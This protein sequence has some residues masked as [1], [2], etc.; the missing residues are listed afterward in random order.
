MLFLPF[1]DVNPA[2]LQS[3]ESIAGFKNLSSQIRVVEVLI[4]GY[5]RDRLVF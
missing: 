2:L 1:L 3:L 5:F 4:Y